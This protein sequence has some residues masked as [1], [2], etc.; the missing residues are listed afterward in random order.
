MDHSLDTLDKLGK[1]N[2]SPNCLVMVIFLNALWMRNIKL[3]D[4]CKLCFIFIL[5]ILHHFLIL[6]DLNYFA[7]FYRTCAI[8]ENVSLNQSRF[9][10]IQCWRLAFG[11][12]YS[13][14]KEVF[15]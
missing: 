4:G 8:S 7:Y 14:N 3:S 13:N 11:N 2:C 12:V 1:K 15:D 9:R 5:Y 6:Q 10:Y